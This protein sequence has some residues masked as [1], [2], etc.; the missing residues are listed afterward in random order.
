MRYIIGIDEVGR[1]ALAGP[2]AVSAVCIPRRMRINMSIRIRD[3][4][5]G[6]LRDS[7]KLTVF[8]RERWVEYIRNHPQISFAL[9]RVYP[10]GVD[11]MNIARAA[12][13]A[14][15]RSYRRLATSDLRQ[16]TRHSV[17]LDGGLYLG[18]GKQ[19]KNARTVVRGDEKFTAVK[20]A[21]IVAKVSRDSYMKKLHKKYPQYGF[22]AHKGYGTRAHRAAL[23]KHGPSAV[24][25]LTFLGFLKSRH[26][27]DS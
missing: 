13:E 2:V 4:K 8:Q 19:P 3:K 23:E 25:R 27:R 21:S 14:A 1:G 26:T 20:L 18:N 15:W 7:K 22:A 9:A 24:H 12:N 10:R 5:L 17:F 11:R 16:A 6:E